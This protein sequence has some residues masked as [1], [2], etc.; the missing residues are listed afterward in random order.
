MNNFKQFLEAIIKISKYLSKNKS[1]C[2]HLSILDEALEVRHWNEELPFI[3]F[4]SDFQIQFIQPR[5]ALFRFRVRRENTPKDSFVS[6]YFDAYQA[7]GIFDGPYFE[8]Y[9]IGDYAND[10]GYFPARVG[11]HETND[12]IYEVRKALD[13]LEKAN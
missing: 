7:L 9:P 8:V 13:L 3:H 11:I 12:L 1:Y 2:M 4:P 5:G 10:N 6:V